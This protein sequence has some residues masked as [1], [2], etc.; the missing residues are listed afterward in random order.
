MISKEARAPLDHL[1][2]WSQKRVR[3]HNDLKRKYGKLGERYLG[4]TPFSD[5]VLTKLDFV[6]A[7][8]TSIVTAPLSA[9]ILPHVEAHF[10]EDV[11]SDVKAQ[12]RRVVVSLVLSN[13][14]SWKLRFVDRLS[15][16]TWFLQLLE[17][18][19][20]SGKRGEICTCAEISQNSSLLP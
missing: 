13:L 6:P 8:F 19:P 20:F 7:S 1:F 18:E 3:Q 5:L 2:A 17:V 9:G 4:T 10:P 12:C 15:K 14:A 16:W 11:R